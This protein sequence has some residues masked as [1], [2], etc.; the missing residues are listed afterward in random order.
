MTT[1]NGIPTAAW[2]INIPDRKSLH[3]KPSPDELIAQVL[4]VYVRQTEKCLPK[5]AVN[6]TEQYFA[7]IGDSRVRK[8]FQAFASHLESSTQK[9]E[10]T[11]DENKRRLS[12]RFQQVKDCL[13]YTNDKLSLKLSY[14]P[15]SIENENVI[16]ML[17]ETVS[18]DPVSLARIIVLN[19]G[20]SFSEGPMP[21]LNEYKSGLNNLIQVTNSFTLKELWLHKLSKCFILDSKEF[22][23]QKCGQSTPVDATNPDWTHWTWIG[24]DGRNGGPLQ[25]SG[26]GGDHQR[27]HFLFK[28]YTWLTLDWRF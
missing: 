18:N 21:S 25:P 2:S 24:E 17:R 9:S 20:F 3:C 12:G 23:V 6:G 19:S 28:S 14:A 11:P 4:F 27:P 16:A 7:F 15:G 5:G 8:L 26:R 1:N 22:V 13:V 10:S